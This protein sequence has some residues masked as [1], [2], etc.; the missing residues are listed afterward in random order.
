MNARHAP[1]VNG[2]A[3]ARDLFAVAAQEVDR[4]ENEAS[5]AFCRL[6]ALAGM[7]ARLERLALSHEAEVVEVAALYAATICREA[8]GLRRYIN[9]REWAPFALPQT[10]TV[11][12]GL[13]PA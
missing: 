2:V 6:T 4:L 7:L 10:T 8:E 13:V 11:G 9:S 12:N 3:E 1:E 5:Q